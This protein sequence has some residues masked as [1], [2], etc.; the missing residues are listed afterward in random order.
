MVLPAVTEDPLREGTD[1]RPSAEHALS[2]ARDIAEIAREA[3]GDDLLEVWFYGSRARG[4]W[5]ADSDLDLLMPVAET[6]GP[7]HY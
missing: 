6:D 2:A 5:Q 3:Y 1:P 7:R 4:D